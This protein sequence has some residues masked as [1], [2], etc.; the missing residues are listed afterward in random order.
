MLMFVPPTLISLVYP[1]IFIKALGYAGG[2]SCAILFGFFPP[3]MV[4][5]GRYMKR[6]S[7]ENQQLR[8][9]KPLLAILCLF[10]LFELGVQVIDSF[11]S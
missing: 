2:I 9:G 3:A 8:G 4:W 1:D 10:V 5:V 6:Y 11:F 7:L